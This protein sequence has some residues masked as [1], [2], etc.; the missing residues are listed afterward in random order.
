[1]EKGWRGKA[2]QSKVALETHA[3]V[4]AP[5][6]PEVSEPQLGPGVSDI[7]CKNEWPNATS[8]LQKGSDIFGCLMV[9]EVQDYPA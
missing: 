8:K 5:G 4:G 6:D 3:D 1:M 9:S 2:S 7:T